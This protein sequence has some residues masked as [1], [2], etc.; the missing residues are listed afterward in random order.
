MAGSGGNANATVN[1]LVTVAGGEALSCTCTVTWKLP[2]VAG[3]PVSRPL[4]FEVAILRSLVVVE[5]ATSDQ[6]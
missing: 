5:L 1:V 6:V 2:W 3:V 4:L